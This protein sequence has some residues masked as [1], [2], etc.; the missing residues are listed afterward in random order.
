MAAQLTLKERVKL[1]ESG[2]DPNAVGPVVANGERAVGSMQTLPSTLKDP[3]FG[4]KPAQDDTPA[5]FER[6]GGDYLD[7]M[8]KRYDGNERLALI[9]YNW[10][11]DHADDIVTGA[12]KPDALPS[13]TRNYLSKILGDTTTAAPK[14]KAPAA[15]AEGP[16]LST[17]YNTPIAPTQR[18]AY[19]EW[20]STL[21]PKQRSLYD[22]DL[23]GAFLAGA[24]PSEN[25]H[26]P[27]T[28]KKPN[29]PTFSDQSQYAGAPGARPGHW[30]GDTFVPPEEKT[31]PNASQEAVGPPKF[32][33]TFKVDGVSF[34]VNADSK[35]KA[36]AAQHLAATLKDQPDLL[37]QAATSQ[38]MYY[39]FNTGR[40]R[41]YTG[42]EK[43]L[44]GTGEV[45]QRTI[46][47]SKE[48][49]NKATGNAEAVL[50]LEQKTDDERALFANLDDK[51]LGAED[52][53]AVFAF[54]PLMF[55]PGGILG[56]TALS[57]AQ[58]GVS[59]TGTEDTHL[60]NAIEGAAAGALGFRGGQALSMA[61]RGTVN[62]LGGVMSAMGATGV[63]RTAAGAVLDWFGA[64]GAGTGLNLLIK[65]GQ[66]VRK[67]SQVKGARGIAEWDRSGGTDLSN[68]LP[69]DK[70]GS[71]LS[72]VA[73]VFK[74]DAGKALTKVALGAK[75]DTAE[76]IAA[77]QAQAAHA[78]TAPTPRPVPDYVPPQLKP[79]KTVADLQ[80]NKQ[81]VAAAKRAHTYTKNKIDKANR[82]DAVAHANGAREAN[83]I[84]AEATQK[85]ADARAATDELVARL[86]T[87]LIV[88][89]EG[90]ARRDYVR[91]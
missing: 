67:A 77:R 34:T 30:E 60:G 79:A 45:Y 8:L 5:E 54:A 2:G 57:G 28:F 41:E 69:G 38:G 7:A 80:A 11:P 9:A 40:A 19:N 33:H 72:T 49:Y 53:G 44:I 87:A 58:A 1:V 84:V 52:L 47:G 14:G 64:G 83:R 66:I 48:L 70:A 78:A 55:G 37:G 86:T 81:A 90:S 56:V 43:F 17:K 36:E 75:G 61:G 50:N 88:P 63:A 31:P 71:W 73:D 42:I 89:A 3:G 15:R 27:D 29:H 16:D 76:V 91:K 23:Q 39:D 35:D 59:A 51:G 25:G 13:E 12:R 82:A 26:L 74:S 32:K 46:D 68:Q 24:T 4:V 21:A 10:G 85:Q 22:Y 18:K 20:L 65:A 62:T 6:V